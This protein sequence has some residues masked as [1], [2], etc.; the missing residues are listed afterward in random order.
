MPKYWMLGAALA[1]SMACSFA[2]RAQTTIPD[3]YNKKIVSRSELGTL[4]GDFAGD[5]ID[6]S[7][8]SLEIVQTDI[9]LP[10]N[11]ALP[12]RVARR[13]EPADSNFGGHFGRWRMDIPNVHGT[14]ADVAMGGWRVD[15]TEGIGYSTNRCSGF[16]RPPSGFSVRPPNG[17]TIWEADDYWHGTFFHLPGSG[18]Q[19]LLSRGGARAPD[20]GHAYYAVTKAGAVARCVALSPTSFDPDYGEGFEMVTP[21]GTVYTLN[22]MIKQFRITL[23][24]GSDGL[25]RADYFLYPTRVADRFGNTVTY[26]WNP[27]NSAQLLSIVASDGRRLD[28]TY[29]APDSMR[30][31]AVTDGSRTWH[32]AYT[33]TVGPSYDPDTLTLP[34]GRTWSFRL[35]YLAYMPVSAGTAHCD[36]I[37]GITQRTTYDSGPSG[38]NPWWGSITGP[39]GATVKFEMASVMLGRSQVDYNC[40]SETEESTDARPENPYLFYTAAVVDKTITGPGLP[41]SGLRWSYSYGP[42]NNCWKGSYSEG[43]ACTSSSPVTRTALLTDPTGA[44]TRYTFGNQANV[45]EGMLFK[46]EYGW[47]GASAMQTV[48]IA[49]G[50][51]DAAPYGT[52]NGWSLRGDGD[53]ALTSKNQPQRKLT[54]T[55]QGATFTWEVAANC[56]GM[57]YCFD[58][59]ARPTN[60]VRAGVNSA[61]QVESIQYDD[62]TVGWVLGQV[63]Q[64]TVDGAA[65][66]RTD[67]NANHQPWKTYAFGKLKNTFTYNADGTIATVADGNNNVTTYSSWKRGIPQTVHFPATPEATSGAT[68][69]AVVSDEG[70]I[71][72]VT[73][74]NGYA[75]GYAYDLMG[76]IAQV[77][78][79]AGDSVA[80]APTISTFAPVGTA[81]NGIAAGHWKQTVHT[82]NAYKVTLL[83]A[84]WRPVLVREYDAANVA[85][86]D[87]YVA[88]AYDNAGRVADVSYPLGTTASAL[89]LGGS[90]TWLLGGTRP[91]GVRTSYDALGRPTTVQQ[92]S[93]LGV[94]T[95]TT[96]YLATV[97]KR[98]VT[99]ARGKVTT[100]QFM[101]RGTPSFD[102]PVRIDAPEGQVTLIGRDTFGKPTTITRGAGL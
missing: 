53:P 81:E 98:R 20:D 15:A 80:W 64:R 71:T 47:N 40:I 26:N 88:T 89:T 25:A 102:S 33:A 50:A 99:D 100:E 23:S 72:S 69:T 58:A 83:D 21:D 66:E 14:F 36:G 56:S 38:A 2:V 18:D 79:P 85:G 9:D 44:V 54:T 96:E 95:T 101:A 22:Q 90:A 60:V 41:S 94:L 1:A 62:D 59:F 27:G 13:F 37:N 12:V 78:Y 29:E 52:H 65:A 97:F 51:A 70:W 42:T 49:Y 34:D 82:G 77:T 48:E 74:E 93:E 76:R 63:A 8:G 91:S 39:S 30:V 87:H 43:I 86:T 11:N 24:K 16:G 92:D 67:F 57:P 4:T 73:D 75:T 17:T 5:R 35:S 3:E 19:E 28:F 6:M 45:D 68:R 55:Q 84:L 32:Y 31:V 7:S 46:T 61:P 10:G